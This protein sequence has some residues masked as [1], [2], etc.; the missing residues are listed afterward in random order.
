MHI[1]T[2]IHLFIGAVLFSSRERTG[3][4]IWNASLSLLLSLSLSPC[5]SPRTHNERW[6]ILTLTPY[7]ISLPL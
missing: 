5:S 7:C 1:C 3:L 6:N 4:S 2:V